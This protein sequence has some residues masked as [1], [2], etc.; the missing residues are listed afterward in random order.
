[1]KYINR[2]NIKKEIVGQPKWNYGE[3]ITKHMFEEAIMSVYNKRLYLLVK[4][5]GHYC[6]DHL[7][8]EDPI[9]R[10][11]IDDAIVKTTEQE[12]N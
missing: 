11:M 6:C 3:I 1:M 7:M 12:D 10:K 4:I 5:Y 2:R 8:A 9:V